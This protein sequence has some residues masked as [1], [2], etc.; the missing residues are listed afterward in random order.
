MQQIYYTYIAL[1]EILGRSI[2]TVHMAITC[3][4][5]SYSCPSFLRDISLPGFLVVARRNIAT[6]RNSVF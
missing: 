5:A 6:L 4:Y 3:A 1:A 2:P